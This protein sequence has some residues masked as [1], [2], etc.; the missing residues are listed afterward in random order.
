MLVGY[1]SIVKMLT[2]STVSIP[3]ILIRESSQESHIFMIE[4]LRGEALSQLF[5]NSDIITGL[6]YEYMT[7]EPVVAQK[8]NGKNTLLVFAESEDIE[9]ICNTLQ[10]IEM[11]L[12]HSLN[13][14]HDVAT[15]KQGLM[16]DQLYQVQ[17]EEIMLVEGAN[18]QLPRQMPL[19]QHNISCPSDSVASKVVGKMPNFSTFSGN[20]TQKGKLLFAQWAFK[21]KGVM[22]SHIEGTLREGVKVKVLLLYSMVLKQSHG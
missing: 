18:M 15:P 9:N 17:S 7:I 12:G 10:S 16:G 20:S 6:V 4:L 8:L 1:V 5:T 14:R 19:P 11:W 13:I 2:S 21:V 22:Q 3:L